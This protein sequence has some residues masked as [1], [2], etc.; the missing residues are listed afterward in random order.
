MD[1]ATVSEPK[2]HHTHCGHAFGNG[3]RAVHVAAT[4]FTG[5][6]RRAEALFSNPPGRSDAQVRCPRNSPNCARASAEPLAGGNFARVH[7]EPLIGAKHRT[8]TLAYLQILIVLSLGPNSGCRRQGSASEMET[9]KPLVEQI[10][11]LDPW[12][13]NGKYT[14]ASWKKMAETAYAVQGSDPAGVS[15]ALESFVRSNAFVL[16]E[17]YEEESKPFLLLRMVFDL[18]ETNV[19]SSN[20]KGFKAWRY[21]GNGGAVPPPSW[22]VG[23]SSGKPYLI[24]GWGGSMGRSYGAAAEYQYFLRTFPFRDLSKLRNSK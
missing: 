4:W 22:P 2:Q 10:A 19:V 20:P 8:I 9:T 5:L 14:E 11:S 15:R 23:W 7:R 17:D 12:R 24:C 3:K 13:S 18:P 6:Y 1:F 21:W 16:H